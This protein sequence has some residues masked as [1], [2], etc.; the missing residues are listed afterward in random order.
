MAFL[1]FSVHAVWSVLLTLSWVIAQGVN[2]L[3]L[4]THACV[5]SRAVLVGCGVEKVTMK[6]VCPARYHSISAPHSS[7]N[8]G[9]VQQATEP[10]D[11]IAVHF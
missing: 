10:R 5:N 7:V 6:H 1:S 8:R 3:I 9:L 11:S 4:T 2:C